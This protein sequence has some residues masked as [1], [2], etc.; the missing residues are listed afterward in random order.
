MQLRCPDPDSR[1]FLIQFEQIMREFGGVIPWL[2]DLDDLRYATNRV[3]FTGELSRRLGQRNGS[4]IPHQF[5][6]ENEAET[7]IG[8][9]LLFG[10]SPENL[11]DRRNGKI[12]ER[13]ALEGARFISCLQVREPKRGIGVG[14]KM[15]A[16]AIDVI[17]EKSGGVWG[18]VSNPDLVSWYEAL[19]GTILSPRN[20][21]DNLWIIHFP[22]H[23]S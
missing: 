23:Q 12:A 2:D 9:F 1:E 19:G 22:H 5:V 11:R 13:L 16:R 3:W 15:M 10:Q 6:E 8:G 17:R 14:K 18:V 7:Y 4:V 20:N 21:D